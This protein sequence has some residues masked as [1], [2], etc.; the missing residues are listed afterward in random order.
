MYTETPF[1]TMYIETLYIIMYTE[2]P[3]IPMYTEMPYICQYPSEKDEMKYKLCRLG[4]ELIPFSSSIT[5]C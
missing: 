5:L 4:F 1:I 3:Y 2:T